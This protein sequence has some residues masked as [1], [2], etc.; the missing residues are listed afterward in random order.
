MCLKEL[1]TLI[2]STQTVQPSIKITGKGEN[3]DFKKKRTNGLPGAFCSWVPHDHTFSNVSK[4]AKIISKIICG[5]EKESA[6]KKK[7]RMG[8]RK[9]RKQKQVFKNVS[10]LKISH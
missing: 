4:F 6:E 7:M 2:L 1:L 5:A 8:K 3:F 9:R 10:A